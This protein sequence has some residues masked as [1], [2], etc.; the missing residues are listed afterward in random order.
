MSENWPRYESHKI[1]RAAPIIGIAGSPEDGVLVY[2]Q[3]AGGDAEEFSPNV[4]AMAE[5]AKT[6]DYAVVYEDGF[7]S[8][9]P[10]EA[11]EAGYTRVPP[12]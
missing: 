7:K 12:T 11:F 2:V 9:S 3:P 10:K 4:V 8:I 5:R 6:G 1:V